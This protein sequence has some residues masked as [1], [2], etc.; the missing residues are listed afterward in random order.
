[1]NNVM[2]NGFCEL[3]EDEM[4]T[5]EGGASN[6]VVAVRVIGG[7]ALV[8]LVGVC[9]AV[10]APVSVPLLLVGAAVGGTSIGAASWKY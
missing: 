5:V 2:T 9:A 8:G 3:N 10:S 6:G 1:M 4:V 7:A